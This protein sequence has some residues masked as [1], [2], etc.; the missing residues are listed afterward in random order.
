[1][2]EA[3]DNK[4]EEI[5]EIAHIEWVP[6]YTKSLVQHIDFSENG[7]TTLTD[8]NKH[9]NFDLLNDTSYWNPKLKKEFLDNLSSLWDKT[10]YEEGVGKKD[11]NM[12]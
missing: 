6:P 4:V 12:A 9:E 10:Y 5:H 1:M 7:I 3:F 11:V 8:L 2:E